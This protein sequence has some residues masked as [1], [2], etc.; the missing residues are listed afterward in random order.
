[1]LLKFKNVK[2][3]ILK[4]IF[5]YYKKFIFLEFDKTGFFEIEASFFQSI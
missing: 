2:G 1:M 5:L 3:K 4:F